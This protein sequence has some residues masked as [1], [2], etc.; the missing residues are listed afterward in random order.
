MIIRVNFIKNKEINAFNNMYENEI[1]KCIDALS[2]LF[3]DTNSFC[4][5]KEE[6]KCE[7]DQEEKCCCDEDCECNKDDGCKPNVSEYYKH[8]EFIDGEKVFEK[9]Q[10]KYNGKTIFETEHDYIKGT[11]SGFGCKCE[12][13]L[14]T[15]SSQ[16]NNSEKCYKV[17]IT[18]EQMDEF[19]NKIDRI[20]EKFEHYEQMIQNLSQENMEL[21]RALKR[22]ER[23]N[24][25]LNLLLKG[26]TKTDMFIYKLRKLMSETFD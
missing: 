13:S 15:T 6:C 4:C 20:E 12:P 8:S 9:E 10:E 17:S 19:N 2:K 14:G 3:N 5:G 22:M 1:D 24:H 23:E 21:A 11:S 18:Q 16:C 7:K 25:E 26:H